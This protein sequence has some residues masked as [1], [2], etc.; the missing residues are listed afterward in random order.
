MLPLQTIRVLITGA[1]LLHAA[2][3]AIALAA[4]VAQCLAGS[5]GSRVTVQSWLLRSL[6]PR[7]AAG[8]AVL[9][10]IAATIGFLAASLAFWGILVRGDVWRQLA[11][12]GSIAS[13][14][15]IA[16]FSGIWPGSPNRGRSVLNMLVAL[17]MNA[18]IL[19]TQLGLHWPPQAMFGK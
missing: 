15:G 6:S 8:V 2:A 11:I 10:W 12:A 13:L 14:S 7:V 16:L 17:A 5:T 4:L 1:F 3:H 19:A 18:V 9:F